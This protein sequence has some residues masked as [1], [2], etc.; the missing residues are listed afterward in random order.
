MLFEGTMPEAGRH[1]VSL[2]PSVA[3]A[4][5][6]L[7]LS[8]QDLK[9]VYISLGPGS[10]TG[11]RIGIAT[12]KM[13]ALTLDV[14]IVGVASMDAMLVN[15]PQDVLRVAIGLNHKRGRAYAA[16]FERETL[17]EDAKST[18]R[19]TDLRCDRDI[20]TWLETLSRPCAVLGQ[21]L[22]LSQTH[23]ASGL[24]LLSE[25]LTTVKAAAVWELGRTL[26]K[27]GRFTPASELQ[28]IY[29]REPEAVAL[30]RERHG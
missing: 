25:E 14:Q 11:L 2:M 27:Q 28:P 13:L 10:F 6:S 18:W 30:W 22:E 20:A 29:V 16:V 21:Q 26:G 8:P 5:E 7:S 23:A 1:N 24:H 17:D 3:A 4:F 9:H 12:A 19:E 15:V